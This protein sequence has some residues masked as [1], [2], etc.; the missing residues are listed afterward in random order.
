MAEQLRVDLKKLKRN[1]SNYTGTIT[2]THNRALRM[3]EEDPAAQDGEQLEKMK[4][5]IDKAETQYKESRASCGICWSDVEEDPQKIEDHEQA[6]DEAYD[7]FIE[8]A[9]AARK[10]VNR[11]LALRSASLAVTSLKNKFDAI[12]EAILQETTEPQWLHSLSPLTS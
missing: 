1:R 8:H 5:S 11:L 9:G 2:R 4:T 6:E 10:L 7:T 12:T 3:L